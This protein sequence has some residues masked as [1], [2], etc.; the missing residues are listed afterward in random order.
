MLF[1]NTAYTHGFTAGKSQS[2]NT[3][4]DSIAS[5]FRCYGVWLIVYL[6]SYS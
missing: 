6:C 4:N 1:K 2:V 3:P 5:D